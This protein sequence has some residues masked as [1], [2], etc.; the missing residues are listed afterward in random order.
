MKVSAVGENRADRDLGF[1]SKIGNFMAATSIKTRERNRI[2]RLRLFGR[3]ENFSELIRQ[4]GFVLSGPVLK[5]RRWLRKKTP[6]AIPTTVHY[7]ETPIYI[8]YGNNAFNPAMKRKTVRLLDACVSLRWNLKQIRKQYQ[9]SPKAHNYTG[10]W[11][12]LM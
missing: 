6:K 8:D 5:S 2:N 12:E 1:W 11:D 7:T 10:A 3:F 4:F 9:R